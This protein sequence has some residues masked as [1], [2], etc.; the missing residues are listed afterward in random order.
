[1]LSRA[2]GI[3]TTLGLTPV[4]ADIGASG[5]PPAVWRPIASASV[6]VGFDPDLRE[7][8][9]D[10]GSG[11]RR[12]VIMNAA[13]T[14]DS[15]RRETVLRLTRFPYCSSTLKPDA[16]GLAG[17]LF[18]DLF[19]V[20]RETSVPCTTLDAAL[21]RLELPGIDWLKTDTQ[22]TDLRLFEGLSPARRARVLALDVE[23]GLIRAYE[24]EDSFVETHRRLSAEGWWLSRM[25]VRGTVRMHR[26]SLP[27]LAAKLPGAGDAFIHRTVR[28]SPAWVEAR[29]LRTCRWLVEQELGRREWV[30]LWVFSV[31]DGQLGFAFD[32]AGELLA[33]QGLEETGALLEGETCAL[34]RRAH[35]RRLVERIAGRLVRPVRRLWSRLSDG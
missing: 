1:M 7:I 31:L 21:D 10:Q 17:Y 2:G 15:E 14:A 11:F 22:G 16:E 25:D 33:R 28:S 9:E 32:V 19:E 35:R 12:S 23:P 4:L 6:Y 27:R 29:Y 5:G 8:R 20:E 34:L 18:S 3:V 26:S 24:G 30:L 13:A